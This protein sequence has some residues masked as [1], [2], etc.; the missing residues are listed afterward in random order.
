MN[1]VFFLPI[2]RSVIFILGITWNYIRSCVTEIIRHKVG[3][4][5]LPIERDVHYLITE[6]EKYVYLSCPQSKKTKTISFITIY[7]Y[8]SSK[9]QTIHFIT[10][11]RNYFDFWIHEIGLMFLFR[12]SKVE[13]HFFFDNSVCSFRQRCKIAALRL[14]RVKIIS[15]ISNLNLNLWK[16]K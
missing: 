8:S 15:T 7:T 9:I 11:L 5:D 12:S 4:R 10:H 14:T 1:H 16:L 2:V 6:K 3:V 13:Y